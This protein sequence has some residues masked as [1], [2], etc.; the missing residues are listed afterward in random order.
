MMDIIT[1][2]NKRSLDMERPS[3]TKMVDRYFDGG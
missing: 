2:K 1:Q 3:K